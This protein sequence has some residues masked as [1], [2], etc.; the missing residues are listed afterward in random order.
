VREVLDATQFTTGLSFGGPAVAVTAVVALA[1]VAVFRRR[2]PLAGL[3]LAAA[4]LLAMADVFD[5]PEAL[6]A[7]IVVLAIAGLI[8]SLTPWSDAV[9]LA[10]SIPG[11]LMVVEA[12]GIPDVSWM[13]PLIVVTIV[14]GGTAVGSFDERWRAS[15][16]G[17]VL[18]PMCVAGVYLTVPDTEHLLVLVG[19]AIAVPILGWPFPLASLGRPGAYGAIALLMWA[20]AVDGTGR[21][22]S[23]IGAS[24]CF[25]FFV[26]EAIVRYVTRRELD[27]DRIPHVVRVVPYA[28][29]HGAV[30][31]VGSRVAGL[32]TEPRE[33]AVMGAVAF[34]LALGVLMASALGAG[35]RRLPATEQ[36]LTPAG[37]AAAPD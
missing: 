18:L 16:F 30:V 5:I 19:V 33:A 25:G 28:V 11:A 13:K 32:R 10:L 20:A 7:G 26:A 6:V 1:W 34:G 31:Y 3:A 9:G 15:T 36:T 37:S 12:D 4:G 21:P 17:P 22:A 8:A 14:L 29:A 24:A 35:H 27:L 2:G 23:V